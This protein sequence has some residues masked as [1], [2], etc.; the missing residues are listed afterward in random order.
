MRSGVPATARTATLTG[1]S[2]TGTRNTNQ[3][4]PKGGLDVGALESE[5]DEE[6]AVATRLR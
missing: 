4:E 6:W 3:T 2:G 1:S 5:M